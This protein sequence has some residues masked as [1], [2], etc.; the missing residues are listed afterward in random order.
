MLVLVGWW[1][2]DLLLC[3]TCDDFDCTGCCNFEVAVVEIMNVMNLHHFDFD[4]CLAVAVCLV[5]LLDYGLWLNLL[6][7]LIKGHPT[8]DSHVAVHL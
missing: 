5:V 1:N 7:L 2:T 3:L 4:C 8:H 6:T